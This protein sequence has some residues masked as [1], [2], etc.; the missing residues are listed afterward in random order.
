MKLPRY[1]ENWYS[2]LEFMNPKKPSIHRKKFS[3]SC[4]ELKLV[5][6]VFFSKFGCHG[7]SLCSLENTDSIFEFANQENIPYH[8]RKNCLYILYK[9]KIYAI[10][11]HFRVNLVAMATPFAPLKI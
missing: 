6:F 1:P 2:K 10:F 5:H 8:T 11:Y 3:I 7:N 4:K 9:T